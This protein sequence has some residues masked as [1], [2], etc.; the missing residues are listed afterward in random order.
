MVTL[1]NLNMADARSGLSGWPPV[2]FESRSWAPSAEGISRRAFR[3]H[4]G[5]Y[6]AAVTPAIAGLTPSIGTDVQALVAEA[7]AALARV[8][9]SLALAG[10]APL[11]AVL[12]RTESASSSQIEQLT[13]SARSLADAELGEPTGQNARMVVANVRAMERALAHEGPVTTAALLDVHATLVEPET[14]HGTGLRGEQVWIGGA[15]TGPHLAD[16]VPPHH[17]GVASAMADLCAFTGRVDLPALVHAAVAHAQFE[18]IHPFTDGNGR[19]GRALIHMMLREADLTRGATVP[20]SAGLLHDTDAYFAAL[21][22]FRDGDVEPVVARVAE[23]ALFAATLARD[24]SGSLTSMAQEW[25]G[26]IR[27]R[28][29]AAVWSLIELLPARP[30]VSYDLVRDSLGVSAPT[31]YAAIDALVD[32]GV[33]RA[34]GEG[35]RNRVWDAVEVLGALDDFAERARRG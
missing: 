30:V 16:F 23:A 9:A 5:P 4:S 18:T 32:V 29:G 25:R 31:A 3:A 34:R 11:P 10:V 26:R 14:V 22:A 20:V 1:I 6:L 27:A 8:D 24:L 33:L 35:R 15:R 7:T 28:S 19:T 13:A 12:L 17:D 21:G 2:S